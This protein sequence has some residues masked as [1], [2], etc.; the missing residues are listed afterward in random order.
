MI[1]FRNSNCSWPTG[2]SRDR[3]YRRISSKFRR[4]KRSRRRAYPAQPVVSQ[5]RDPLRPCGRKRSARQRHGGGLV[6]VPG[7]YGLGS[8]ASASASGGG[9]GQ[10]RSVHRADRKAQLGWTEQFVWSEEPL[11]E[12]QAD[13][14]R[15]LRLV[16]PIMAL[17]RIDPAGHE[18][19]RVVAGGSGLWS[20]ATSNF[21]RDPKFV[22]EWATAST[23]VRSIFSKRTEPYMS[24]AIGRRDAAR[25]FAEN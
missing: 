10:N 19:V 11:E 14:L 7:S 16:P 25:R 4:G 3:L 13:A 24:L 17:S 2:L 8:F 21:S 6:L 9:G 15:L 18:Q 12:R 5:I 1:P 23:T 20:E 22:A